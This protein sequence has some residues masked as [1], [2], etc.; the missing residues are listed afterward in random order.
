MIRF[1][2]NWCPWRPTFGEPVSYTVSISPTN[3][4]SL[5]IV[6]LEGMPV[7]P[8]PT[9]K[10]NPLD[11]TATPSPEP[12]HSSIRPDPQRLI[13]RKPDPSFSKPHGTPRTLPAIGN[14]K[15]A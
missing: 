9:T 6:Q 1:L 14:S 5:A 2:Q 12:S 11:F 13:T 4:H 7:H 15:A 10:T 8:N 3:I